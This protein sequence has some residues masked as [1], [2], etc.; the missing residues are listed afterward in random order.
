MPCL[1][2]GLKSLKS[3]GIEDPGNTVWKAFRGFFDFQEICES[4]PGLRRNTCNNKQNGRLFCKILTTVKNFLQ[5]LL[6]FFHQFL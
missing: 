3:N 4:K 2:L 1:V 5:F 6:F